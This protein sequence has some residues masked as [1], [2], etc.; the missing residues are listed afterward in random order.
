MM[1]N[2]LFCMMLLILTA[3]CDT[4]KKIVY[5]QDAEIDKTEKIEARQTILIE[6]KDMLSIVVTSR[7]QEVSAMFNLIV[8]DNQLGLQSVSSANAKISGYIVDNEG[9]IDFPVLGKINA[10]GMTRWQLQEFIMH[11]LNQKGLLKDGIVTVDFMNFKVSVLG[12]VNRPGSYVLQGDKATILE[13]IALAGD[14]TIFGLRD[15][16]YVIREDGD[17]RLSYQLDL[18]SSDIFN[19]PAYYLKQNDVIYVT[20]NEVRAGQSTINQN[21]ARSVTLW[22]SIAS[23]LTSVGVIIANLVK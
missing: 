23:L 8:P 7:N 17:Q 14:L 10:K 15:K 19:S 13:A 6:P 16:V 18:R 20:P 5:L 2:L 21:S 12:E 3:S 1:R 22:M 9:F 4:P 11:E